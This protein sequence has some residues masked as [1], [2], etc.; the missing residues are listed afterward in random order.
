MYICLSR[1]GQLAPAGAVKSKILKHLAA[2]QFIVGLEKKD[3]GKTTNTNFKSPWLYRHWPN[4][5][6]T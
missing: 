1:Y 2:C 5:S 4:C 6:G 3:K